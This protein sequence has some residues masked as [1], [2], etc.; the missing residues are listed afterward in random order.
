MNW[1]VILISFLVVGLVAVIGSALYIRLGPHKRL[2]QEERQ[3]NDD[4]AARQASSSKTE[5]ETGQR[6]EGLESETQTVASSSQPSPVIKESGAESQTIEEKNIE[7]QVSVVE[8]TESKDVSET[9]S[10]TLTQSPEEEKEAVSIS[11]DAPA[12]ENRVMIQRSAI[13]LAV[14]NREPKGVCK[15]VSIHDGRVYCWVHVINGEG[16]KIIVRWIAKGQKIWETH[17]PVGSNNW[18]TWAY[19]TLRSSMVGLAQADILN[20]DGEVLQALSFEITG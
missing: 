8:D 15:R 19:I 5:R 14:E 11:E 20:D 12:T 10:E 13:S 7:P 16:R 17:L 1:R 3:V 9:L 18:R 6:E 4:I 2:S